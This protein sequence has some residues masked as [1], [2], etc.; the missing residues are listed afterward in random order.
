MHKVVSVLAAIVFVA[1]CDS[2]THA[3]IDKWRATVKGPSKLSAALADRSLDPDLRAH[4]AQALV[5]IGKAEVA[6]AAIAAMPEAERATI[7]SKLVPRLWNDCKL[8]DELQKPTDKQVAAKDALFSL[9]S[10]GTDAQRAEIDEYLVEW[11][12]GYYEGRAALGLHRGEKIVRELGARAAPKLV[13]A[14]RK[15]LDDPGTER[16]VPVF[17]DELLKGIALTGAPEAVE[18]LVG[19]AEKPHVDA[20]LP[21]RALGAL[22]FAYVLEP[23][24][25]R[26]R[27]AELVPFL[28]RLKAIAESK[29]QP[30]ENVNVAF[31]L[32]AAAGPPHCVGPLAALAQ[33]EDEARMWRAVQFGLKC[34]GAEGLVAMAE[35]LPP[36]R[37]YDGAILAKYFWDQVGELGAAAAAPARALLSSKSWIARVTGIEVLARVGGPDDAAAL[38]RLERDGTKARGWW[39]RRPDERRR[40]EPTLGALAVAAAN[41]LEKS[42]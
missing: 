21:V 34:A 28:S 42:R 15:I 14:G 26:G 41:R 38:R 8:L 32:I 16:A 19:I 12:S 17:G 9:R 18:L 30:G 36:G 29:A 39:S 2:A 24:P 37:G 35:A 20:T 22:Y 4:A 23:T 31:E 25:G 6:L 1:A 13:A 3:N 40:P 33:H 7:L 5:S 27:P 10:L 11:L